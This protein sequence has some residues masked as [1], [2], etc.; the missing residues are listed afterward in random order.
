MSNLQVTES[1]LWVW[2]QGAFTSLLHSKISALVWCAQTEWKSGCPRGGRRRTLEEWAKDISKTFLNVLLLEA[3]V[4]AMTLT[5]PWIPF[6]LSI[7]E[8]LCRWFLQNLRETDWATLQKA[9]LGC[10][11][12]LLWG[13]VSGPE[14]KTKLSQRCVGPVMCHNAPLNKWLVCLPFRKDTN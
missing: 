11:W 13:E 2:R 1:P 12:F 10:P 7:G 9:C 6:L 5:R 8:Q 3:R 4:R 14:R